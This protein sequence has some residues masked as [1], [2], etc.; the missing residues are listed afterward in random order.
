MWMALKRGIVVAIGLI[1]Q[2]LFSVSVFMF[3]R[4]QAAWIETVCRIVGVLIVLGILKGSKR[5]SADVPWIILILAVPVFGALLYLFLGRSYRNSDTLKR[6]HATTEASSKYFKQDEALLAPLDANRRGQVKYITSKGGFPA[7]TGNDVKYYPL[8][9]DVYPVMLEELEKAES[10]IFMEYFIIQPGTMWQGI[11]DILERKANAGLDVRVIYDDLGCLSLL[12]PDYPAQLE[13]KGIKCYA[14]NKLLPVRGV[15]M[16]NRDHRK[17]TIID[18]KTVFS[19]GI[20]LADEY[21]NVNSPYGHWKDNGIMIKGPAV[22]NYTVM[23]LT[24]WNAERPQ[25]P[26]YTVYRH[27]FPECPAANGLVSAYGDSPLDDEIVGENVYI[28]ILNQARDYVWIYTPYLI[29]DSEMINAS[30][31]AASR[32]VDVRI[33]VPG[34]PDKKLVYGVTKSYFESLIRGGV[35]IYTY[36]PGFIHSKV[37]VCDDEIAT[38]GTINMDY[39][40]LYLHFECGN[41]LYKVDAIADVKSDLDA[42]IALSH[43]VTLEEATPRPLQGI[44][45]S[46]LRL[47]APLM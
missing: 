18:G 37:F 20:N 14:F 22:W 8:G 47:F 3:F 34:V 31:L 44:W 23:F 6:I 41:Y 11:L 28:N 27:D 24:M 1:L 46:L 42:A 12:P 16:N 17:M 4:E 39:R 19:G 26:D 7:T 45:Q 29:I 9:D 15:I 40:S 33:V 10:F 21:I 13:A 30:I 2:I 38:V 5:L 32:G 43:R 36:T 35:S 25:D